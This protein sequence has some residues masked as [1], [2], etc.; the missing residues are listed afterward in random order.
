MEQKNMKKI[1]LGIL[2]LAI[3]AIATYAF[4]KKEPT[5]EPVTYQYRESEIDEKSQETPKELPTKILHDVDFV[6][7]APFGD[8]DDPRQQDGC[9]EINAL[10]AVRWA[11]EKSLS[12]EEALDELFKM[13]EF[14]EKRFGTYHDTSAEDTKI[15]IEEYFDF[16]DIELKYDV[17]AEDIKKILADGAIVIAPADGTRLNNPNYTAPGPTY[18]YLLIRGYDQKN[19]IT[20]DSGTRK[21]EEYKY[22]FN[23]VM[24]ALRDYPTGKH[25]EIITERKAILI[26]RKD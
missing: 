11:Q 16:K 7:Q 1:I 20:N 4:T 9:E 10:M 17:T 22:T 14:E 12:R 5:T 21:G 3:A 24:N 6:S 25:P 13:A 15:L 2:V 23:T 19:F 8:W 18:H 26:I